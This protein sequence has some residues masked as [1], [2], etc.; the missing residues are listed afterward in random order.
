MLSANLYS[1][2]SQRPNGVN[3]YLGTMQT[4]KEFI[5]REYDN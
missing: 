1:Y 4:S 3:G 5:V 2:K